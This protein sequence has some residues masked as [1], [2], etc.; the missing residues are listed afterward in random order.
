[1]HV[2]GVA[3]ALVFLFCSAA[4]SGA[5]AAQGGAALSGRLLNSLS[6]DPVA[7][8]TVRV[9]DLASAFSGDAGAY[10]PR[11]RFHHLARRTTSRVR[12]RPSNLVADDRHGVALVT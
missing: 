5:P 6:G 7:G 4:F 8:A 3:G 1:M 10:E 11:G 2:R 9:G 12:V